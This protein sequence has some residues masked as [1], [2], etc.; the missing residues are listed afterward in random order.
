MFKKL[1]EERVSLLQVYIKVLDT[2]TNEKAKVYLIKRIYKILSKSIKARAIADFPQ[3]EYNLQ[4]VYLIT[5]IK[6]GNFP[7]AFLYASSLNHMVTQ[8]T[9]KNS[10][11]SF[12]GIRSLL[13]KIRAYFGS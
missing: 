13:A 12:I 9:S 5:H 11:K 8:N 6:E 4:I 7:S 3:R 2:C 10:P 1:T